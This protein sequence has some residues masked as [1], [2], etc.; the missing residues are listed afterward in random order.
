MSQSS[1]QSVVSHPLPSCMKIG[2]GA[3]SCSERSF[4]Q[5]RDNLSDGTCAVQVGT[6]FLTVFLPCSSLKPGQGLT[7][8]L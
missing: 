2:G 8:G 5:S 7:T 1:E 3:A 6:P 4:S